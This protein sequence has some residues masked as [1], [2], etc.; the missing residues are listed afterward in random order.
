MAA[1]RRLIGIVDD[2]D[3]VRV[4]L[5]RLCHAYGMD[6]RPFATPYQLFESLKDEPH[7]DCLI[8]DV[9]MPG[10]NGLDAQAWLRDRG[11]TIPAIMIT[12]REDEQTRAR[13]LALG[14]C[15]YL[16]KPMDVTV[17]LNAIK[18]AIARADVS[19]LRPPA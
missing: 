8:L 13:A 7:P 2:E 16:C 3:A 12:G 5:S 1:T 6:P 9:Q 14:A 18:N 19:P 17:L 11:I 15:A 10:F 4:A